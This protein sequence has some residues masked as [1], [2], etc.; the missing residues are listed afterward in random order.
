M[1]YYGKKCLLEISRREDDVAFWTEWADRLHP[2]EVRAILNRENPIE[3]IKRPLAPA[4][5]AGE[6]MRLGDNFEIRPSKPRWVKDR[7]RITFSIRDFRMAPSESVRAR[8]TSESLEG[9]AT[10][11]VLR[12]RMGEPE[13]MDPPT[14]LAR[15]RRA[16][17]VRE[18]IRDQAA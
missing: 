10:L 15:L 11:V 7:Y 18:A 1:S 9:V 6:W 17:S 5:P 16:E 4:W 12:P 14:H 2:D 3:V 8:K 13:R